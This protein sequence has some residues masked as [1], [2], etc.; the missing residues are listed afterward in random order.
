[1]TTSPT[2]PFLDAVAQPLPGA[3]HA[4]KRVDSIVWVVPPEKSTDAGIEGVLAE[5]RE[6]LNGGVPYVAL[7][8]MTSSGIPTALQRKRIAAHMQ[9]NGERIRRLVRGLGVIAPSPLV[10]GVVVALFWV[11]PPKI[12]HRIFGHRAEAID[13]AKTV[14]SSGLTP[15][16]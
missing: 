1:L 5:L 16:L 12:P 8:D 6:H 11:A 13:W 10:R 15:A 3:V 4:T 14:Y 7:F 2:K 9:E